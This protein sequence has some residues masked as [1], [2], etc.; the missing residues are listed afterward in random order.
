[1]IRWDKLPDCGRS[2]PLLLKEEKEG[3]SRTILTDHRTSWLSNV[4]PSKLWPW[5]I[6]VFETLQSAP[7]C[8]W[9]EFDENFTPEVKSL[10]DF[11][12][13]VRIDLLDPQTRQPLRLAPIG[14][15]S[16]DYPDFKSIALPL[17]YT[18]SSAGAQNLLSSFAKYL[19]GEYLGKTK[20]SQ[21]FMPCNF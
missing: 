9:T 6:R 2:C 13:D 15:Q 5:N 1:M 17:S 21:I 16:C 3:N 10:E 11:K 8:D 18:A 12:Y 20:P 14:I 19:T 7:G 4:P